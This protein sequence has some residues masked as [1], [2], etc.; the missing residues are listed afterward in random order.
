MS[1]TLTAVA[2][3]PPRK[4]KKINLNP[5]PGLRP[6][7]VEE[8]H[9]FFGREGQSDDVLV[10]LANHK[11]VAVIGPSGSGKSSF[12][13]CGVVP[14][15]YGGFVAEKSSEWQV[16]VTRVGV[17]PL[18]NLANSILEIDENF[19]Q[20][21]LENQRI[22][23]IITTT[24]L[25]SQPTGLT[26]CIA[27]YP[28]QTPDC[29]YLVIVDQFEEL[30]RY[31][32]LDPAGGTTD[33]A[34]AFVNLLTEAVADTKSNV[35]VALA[36]RSDFI[37]ECSQY[38]ELTRLINE[39]NYLIPQMTREQ[40]RMAILG[41]VAVGGAT[42]APKLVQRLLNELG[43][44]P[45]QLPVLAHALMRTWD[46]WQHHREY[47]TEP[48][49]GKHYEAIGRME[50]ALS[51]HADEAYNELSEMQKEICESMFKSLV[52]RSNTNEGI[53]RPTRLEEIAQIANCQP[54]EVRAVIEKFREPGRA[55]VTPP[56]PAPL[57]EDSVI[58]FSHESLMRIW[59]RL[60]NWVVEEN[61]SIQMYQ[62]LAEAAEMYQVGKAGLWRPPDLQ[63][64]LNWY[65]KEKPTLVWAERYHPAFERTIAFLET[66][67]EKYETEQQVKEMLAKRALRRSQTTAVVLGAAMV[68]SLLFLVYA[69]FQQLEATSQAELAK[70]NEKKAN[71]NAEI[72]RTNEAKAIENAR[73]AETQRLIAEKNRNEA[74]Q[75]VI[76]E[77]AA[78]EEA[79]RQKGI[80]EVQ[81]QIAQTNEQ[82]AKV[83]EKIALDAKDEAIVQTGIAVTERNRADVLKMRT[84]ARAMSNKSIRINDD[85]EQ[86]A[87][88]A[89]QSYIFNKQYGD[90]PDDP[91]V[92]E[93]LYTAIRDLS[94]G[95]SFNQLRGH[96]DEEI[97]SL[98]ALPSGN[99]FFSAG[100]DGRIYRWNSTDFKQNPLLVAKNDFLPRSLAVSPDEKLLANA[101]ETNS[102][103]LFD[104]TSNKKISTL[105]TNDTEVWF[106]AFSKDSKGMIFGDSTT[107]NT[108][109]FQTF[110]EI[111]HFPVKNLSIDLH[112]QLNLLAL[113]NKAGETLLYNLDDHS[114]VILDDNRKVAIRSVAFSHNGKLLATGDVKGVVR[115][116]EVATRKLMHILPGHTAYVN[117]ICFS[118][119]DSQ[120]A[121]ASFDRKVLLWNTERFNEQQP[122]ILTD[123][124]DWIFS[125]VFTPDNK[126]L[127]VG[128][129]YSEMRYYPTHNDAMAD[130]LCNKI[131]R[132]MSPREWMQFVDKDIP[133]QKTCPK[134]EK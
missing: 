2:E 37:G 17:D 62:R 119:D 3:S 92:Y 43:D 95:K 38:P 100:K 10:K 47:D 126:Y 55:L 81:K 89:Q 131:K 73:K 20:E 18:D 41:P 102:I 19:Q 87:L 74:I 96:D 30:F 56:Y 65:L 11:F 28:N 32:L 91:D 93:A 34:L 54:E 90:N 98:A 33:K 31:K 115:I 84:I 78:K 60:K 101:G 26:E 40:K 13:Y 25:Q 127:V 46:Y 29:N 108:S 86:K 1:K 69:I 111:A 107:L 61:E 124:D 24:L 48:I 58:D 71:S 121:T 79:F 67:S 27:Q 9:L 50:E 68:I 44:S 83:A 75:A 122:I 51:Q 113:G 97:E 22:R 39:S 59:V 114:Q 110:K 125:A 106:V 103:Q 120:M 80:A 88:V 4:L 12:M 66:S 35:Y 109:D 8:S 105:K 16:I 64:A 130:V 94:G 104:I 5:F 7:G 112:P 99:A 117:D 6:F 128:G 53:R 45:D 116:W 15:L 70:A 52:G 129:R 57:E 23:K 63:L 132:N 118:Q 85:L 82:K 133:Y 123:H 42:I 14:K 72:A 36:M 76:A 77:K 134:I 21:T 49:E